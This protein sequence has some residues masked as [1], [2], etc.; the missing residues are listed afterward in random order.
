VTLSAGTH[1]GPYEILQVIGS[2]GMGEVYRARDTRLGRT[3]AIKV[4]STD[5]AADPEHRR[6]FEQEA[7]AVSALNHPHICVLHDI[8]SDSG[9]DFLVMEY[10]EGQTLT[11]RL[12][13]GPLPVAQVVEYGIQIADALD[14][15]HRQ[16]IV[17]RDL[18]P[19]NV[20]LTKSGAKLL[21]FGIAKQQPAAPATASA[22][23]T[24]GTIAAAGL[25]GETRLV[26]SLPYM[27]PEQ[28]QGRPVDQRTD[29]FAFGALLYEM[30]VGRRAFDAD[31]QT[32]VIAAVL[33]TDPPSARTHRPDIPA[34]LERLIAT[35]LAKDPAERWQ[36][37]HDIALHLAAF[38]D[39]TTTPID[40]RQGFRTWIAAAGFAAGLALGL[41]SAWMWWRP[42][43]PT[44]A[45]AQL[46]RLSIPLSRETPLVPND[47][48]SAGS[49]L[50]VSRDGR[51]VVYLSQRDGDRRLVL[52]ALDRPEE[53]V[54][55]G[56][57]GALSPFFSPDGE[58]VAFFTETGL[59][60]VPLAGGTPVTICATPPV[61][62]GGV[63]GDDGTIYFSPDFSR[64]LQRVAAAGGRPEDVTRVDFAAGES[65]HLLPELLPG[66]DVLLFTVWKGGSFE[67]ASVWSLS[68][69]TGERK[70]LLESAA[71]ARYLPPGHLVFA[72]AGSLLAVP[73]DARRV[74]LLGS[75]VPVIDNVWSDPSTGTAHYAVARNGT[76]VYA[77]GQY[78]V[79][80]RRLAWVDRQGRAQPLPTEP[81]FY[82]NLKLSPDGRRLAVEMLNDIWVYD[83]QSGTMS[84]VTF[85]GVNEFPVWTPDGRHI[86]FASSQG[87]AYPKLFWIEPEGGGQ[88][89]LLSRE[90]DVQFPGSWTPDGK[91]LAYA[92]GGSEGGTPGDSESLFDIWLLHQGSPRT[93]EVLIRTPFKEDQPMF[94]P[95]GRALAY[96][97]NETGRLQVYIRS[98]PDAGRRIQVST[99]G[100]T[101]PVWSRTGR[102]LFFRNG[103]RYLTVP[104]TTKG[105]IEVGRPSL[106]F[107]KDFVVG[108]IMP[109][110]PSFDVAPDGQRF[111][112]VTHTDDMQWPARLDVVL[113]WV[114]DLEGRVHPQA[115]K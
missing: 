107:E 104:V 111:I 109:G 5:V 73:F 106:L 37:A 78:T 47:S 72:R 30:V 48:P 59:K 81:S 7:R 58:W 74:A 39:S 23:T 18:K 17:H 21:D 85:R 34:G 54:L 11:E 97:S 88:A 82:G 98:F 45:P 55:P 90:G 56:T 42:S 101:E 64:G 57:G 29:I 2:G 65:N 83:L 100:G 33:A 1:L 87:V 27:S 28:L 75:A 52:R 62:R 108:S 3:V 38:Q 14:K 86:T 8:G 24:L 92:E 99:D 35:C 32:G 40:T 9:T 50:D 105:T 13:K 36:T 26:G 63:W 110:N 66:G 93:R 113:N 76:L 25:T 44:A 60:K 41:V 77:P 68:L 20:M 6:R 102:E 70:L 19:A 112:M 79:D 95:D 49:S 46:A 43:T 89:E 114:E 31:S 61:P 53:R 4:L 71:A 10:L 96:V 69:R 12:A 115:Q 80:R 51:R 94:S 84:R 67:A 16:G 91:T 103:R 15:A 22:A